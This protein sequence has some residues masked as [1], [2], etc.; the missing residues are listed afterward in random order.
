M[1]IDGCEH[2]T[3]LYQP[4]NKRGKDI[5]PGGMHLRLSE[6]IFITLLASLRTPEAEMLSTPNALFIT[7][8]ICFYAYCNVEYVSIGTL[9]STSAIKSYMMWPPLRKP[10]EEA[11][12]PKPDF[13]FQVIFFPHLTEWW[14]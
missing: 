7:S 13:F 8:I 12:R 4:Y 1:G 6:D 2:L 11:S 3:E 9:L 10:T 14:R 5:I